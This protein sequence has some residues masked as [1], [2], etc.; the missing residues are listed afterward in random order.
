MA[1]ATRGAGAVSSRRQRWRLAQG[2][3]SEREDVVWRLD[4]GAHGW[5]CECVGRDGRKARWVVLAVLAGRPE[6]EML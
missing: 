3:R 1:T 2:G 5:S 4:L 6:A